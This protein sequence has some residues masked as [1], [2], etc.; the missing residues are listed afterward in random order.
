VWRRSEL[1][2]LG[3]DS[4]DAQIAYYSIAYAAVTALA[5]V[6][7]SLAFAAAPAFANL[8]G[9]EAGERLTVGV[10]RAMRL[11]LLLAIPITAGT[12]VLAPRVVDV[13]YGHRYSSAANLLQLLLI[14][15]PLT[16]LASL[17]TV[18]LNATNQL[19]LQ[20]AIAAVAAVA[21][22]TCAAI[23]VPRWDATGAVVANLVGQLLACVPLM[24][25]VHRRVGGG[26]WQPGR[27]VLC[28]LCSALA[29][30]AAAG[31]CAVLP[32]VLGLAG[33]GLAFLVS[34]LIL[35]QIAPLLS[36]DDARWVGS[37]LG[38]RAQLAFG[39]R[40]PRS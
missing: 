19:R 21:D 12:V 10:R 39:V 1:L 7:Q 27:H 6:P 24:V 28:V 35:V 30:A 14:L 20:M 3:I 13:V 26:I 18:V 2:F 29:A 33:G 22:V 8:V 15:F 17:A 38:H 31:A 32:G 11:M 25:A 36:P 4:S 9:A 40:G 37:T 34:F 5:L 16:P 23:L